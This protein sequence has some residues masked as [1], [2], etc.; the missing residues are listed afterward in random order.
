MLDLQQLSLSEPI[1]TEV[2]IDFD[3]L[4]KVHEGTP[5]NDQDSWV[6]FK[7]PD[8]KV[9]SF[10]RVFA[11]QVR[12]MLEKYWL[13]E[14]YRNVVPKPMPHGKVPVVEVTL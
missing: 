2:V 12:N 3:R 7:T 8:G 9:Q 13:P 6:H 4:P 5:M 1:V 14:S 10:P 11:S